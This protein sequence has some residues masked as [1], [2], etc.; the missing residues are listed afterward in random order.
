MPDSDPNFNPNEF[1]F[2][3]ISDALSGINP[4]GSFDK[5]LKI[6]LVADDLH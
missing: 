5:I 4:I 6:T 2:E 1:I 3:G